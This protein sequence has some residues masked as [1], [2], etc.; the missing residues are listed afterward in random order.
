MLGCTPL[1]LASLPLN[2]GMVD[3]LKKLGAHRKLSREPVIRPE[4]TVSTFR[5][6]GRVLA[7]FLC[8]LTAASECL[9][10]QSIDALTEGAQ[11]PDVGRH[12]VV[13]VVTDDDF[14]E[15]YASL[16]TTQPEIANPH[17]FAGGWNTLTSLLVRN[18][19]N[20]FVATWM[21]KRCSVKISWQGESGGLECRWSNLLDSNQSN[22]SITHEASS[23]VYT[24]FVPPLPDFAAH[25]LLGS[26]EWFVPWNLRWSV[27]RPS[28][29]EPLG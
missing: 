19:I 8:A 16:P 26:G 18:I 21:W 2:Q 20:V 27:P 25:S 29:H 24:S 13:S 4:G 3:I 22:S 10:P 5:T 17:L 9:V 7:S 23:G 11:L 28:S 1:D 14:S 15:P 6:S 12:C